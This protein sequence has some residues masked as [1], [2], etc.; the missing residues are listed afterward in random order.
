MK[1]IKV[2]SLYSHDISSST[3]FFLLKKFSKFDIEFSTPNNADLLFVGPY[4]HNTIKKKFKNKL[5]KILPFFDKKNIFGRLYQP[6]KVFFSVESYIN[7]D[8]LDRDYHISP[9]LGIGRKN[10]LRF[11]SWKEGIDWS[12]FGIIRP[13]NSLNAIR[14]GKLYDLN[15][16]MRPQN[17]YFLK[18]DKKICFFTSHLNEP[19]RS[20]YNMLNKNFAID[21]F[22]PYFNK[23]ISNHN[24][25]QFFKLD[26]MKKYRF[27]LCP[28][29]SLYPGYYDEKIPDAFV[30]KTLPITWCDS[31]VD[32]DFNPSAFINLY[33]YCKS[34]Y[35]ELPS[36]LNDETLLNKFSKEPLI[37]KKIDLEQESI[38][39]EKILKNF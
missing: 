10:H 3:I 13:P 8:N 20:I 11:P 24:S 28:H 30:A 37:L 26:V 29:N 22:G 16:L 9:Y 2:S 7:Q 19:R 35:S 34:D 14:F 23:E 31:N 21:G 33:S 1:K 4:D 39:V 32:V 25:S 6:I 12:N 17:D 38:F 36:I 27:N 15:E 18:K 5:K